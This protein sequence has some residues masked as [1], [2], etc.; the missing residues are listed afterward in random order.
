MKTHTLPV[1]AA[2]KLRY[3]F[4]CDTKP[5]KKVEMELICTKQF[6]FVKPCQAK[7]LKMLKAPSLASCPIQL[8]LKISAAILFHHV[9]QNEA[10]VY[11]DLIDQVNFVAARWLL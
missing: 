4:F 11:V 6:Q 5:N 1:R 9:S 10:Q 2:N 7:S 3:P 8:W